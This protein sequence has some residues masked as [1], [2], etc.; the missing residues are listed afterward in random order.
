MAIVSTAFGQVQPGPLQTAED[1]AVKRQEL[2]FTLRQKLK[3]AQA[4][5]K[6]GDTSG[7]A[8]AGIEEET[9]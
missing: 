4:A 6:R 3:D 9:Q 2:T 8:K 7:A 5:Y 1:E